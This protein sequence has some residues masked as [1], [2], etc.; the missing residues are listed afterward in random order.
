V[1]V[2]LYPFEETVKSEAS[3]EDII[4][5]IDIGGISLIRAAAKNYK[6]VVILSSKND[7]HELE[8]ILIE[9][10]GYTTLEQRK[11]FA[12]KAFHT[13]SHYDTSIFNYFNNGSENPLTVFKHSEDK[14]K[15]LRYGEN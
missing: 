3:E 10:E 6:D 4:E 13:S 8:N 14:V 2:D 7:Y 15:N 12:K 9:N 11:R 5:K 1:I